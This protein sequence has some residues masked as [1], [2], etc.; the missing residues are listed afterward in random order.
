[1]TRI[2]QPADSYASR[3]LIL[4]GWGSEEEVMQFAAEGNFELLQ[5]ESSDIENG[6]VRDV[7][8][9]I[10]PGIVLQYAVDSRSKCSVF[11]LTGTPAEDVKG[12]VESIEQG[13]HPWTL[14]ELLSAVDRAKGTQET[15][16]AVLR[17]GIGAPHQFDKR[18]YKRLRKAV[19]SKDGTIRS[20]GIWATSYSRWEEFRTDL[21]G[22]ARNDPEPGLRRDAQV[23]LD[24]YSGS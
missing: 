17:A 8:W 18:F 14:E 16:E 2:S 11:A 10:T 22:A 9:R 23:I 13:V 1:M 3:R 7:I 24:H 19:R 20:A 12:I 4:Q 15:C 6:I 21:Q 5:D